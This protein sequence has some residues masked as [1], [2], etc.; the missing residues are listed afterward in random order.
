M[1]Q[2]SG[3]AD[4]LAG[5]FQ[6]EVAR[7]GRWRRGMTQQELSQSTGLAQSTISRL[8]S[9]KDKDP[10][11]SALML[12]A[13]ALGLRHGAFL[14]W[15]GIKP[16]SPH[17]ATVHAVL[18][19]CLA[20]HFLHHQGN[21]LRCLQCCLW[22]AMTLR[23][24]VCGLA[25]KVMD[26]DP[27]ATYGAMANRQLEIVT[28]EGTSSAPEDLEACLDHW[29]QSL[30]HVRSAEVAGTVGGFYEPVFMVDFPVKWGMVSWGFCAERQT[31]SREQTLHWVGAA[32]RTIEQGMSAYLS[33]RALDSEDSELAERVARLERLMDTH[34]ENRD[35]LPAMS[36]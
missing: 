32:S 30:P 14:P 8:E 26:V 22:D 28:H 24:D 2:I 33:A 15:G 5:L 29:R 7:L 16:A 34:L 17:L 3:T 27:V 36:H 31:E 9:G 10:P 25:T 13:E 6:G 23:P 18:S 1:T 11:F 12:L 21:I 20:N 19:G 4:R 35:P